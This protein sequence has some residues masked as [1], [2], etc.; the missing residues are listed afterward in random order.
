MTLDTHNV[1]TFLGPLSFNYG[2]SNFIGVILK[3]SRRK[4][5]YVLSPRFEEHLPYDQFDLIIF[6]NMN[7][8]LYKRIINHINKHSLDRNDID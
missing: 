7:K 2:K 5:P 8:N 6:E 4:T 1:N 3:N